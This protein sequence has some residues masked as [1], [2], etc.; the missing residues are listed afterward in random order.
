MDSL[1]R[2]GRIG[3]WSY[4]LD[5]QPADVTRACAAELEALGFPVLWISEARRRE[6]MANAAMLLSATSRL[7]VATGIASIYARDPVT[8]T[9]GRNTLAEAFPGRFILGLGVSHRS[10]V[11]GQRGHTYGPAVATMRAYLAAMSAAN[12]Q[13]PA[14]PAG[15]A[16]TILA[17]LGPRMLE[18][19]RE[20]TDGAHPYHTTPEHT[21]SAR[22]ILGPAPFLAPEQPVVFAAEPGRARAIAR[23]RVTGTLRHPAY[24]RNLLRLGFS[25]ADLADGGSDRLIDS[26][27]AW[28]DEKAVAGRLREHLD[29]GADHVA[30]QIL[31]DDDRVLP[32]R[33]WR[34]LAE[35]ARL[36]GK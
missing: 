26:L 11:E 16:P 33:E 21:R 2:V 12:Y 5:L 25:E 17:A 14:P 31:V 6:I 15:G 3:I 18:L 29:A 7:I 13:S 24:V 8:M 22:E 1:R 30:V 9:C 36:A 20:L 4:Q 10:I 28:G 19:A 35:S 27:V 32:H 34:Q 23:A